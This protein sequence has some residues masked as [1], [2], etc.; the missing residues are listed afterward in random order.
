MATLDPKAMRLHFITVGMSRSWILNSETTR[1][2][3]PKGE[4]GDRGNDAF[5]PESVWDY[6]TLANWKLD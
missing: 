2:K 1:E 3:G 4:K 6:R 5:I